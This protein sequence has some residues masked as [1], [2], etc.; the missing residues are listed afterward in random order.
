MS[1]HSSLFKNYNRSVVF[2]TIGWLVFNDI[3]A[4]VHRYTQ[5]IHIKKDQT[6]SIY[7]KDTTYSLI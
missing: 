3:F 6:F 5:I 1:E 7:L 4:I 2:L